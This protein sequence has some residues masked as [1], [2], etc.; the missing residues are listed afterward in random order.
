MGADLGVAQFE[1]AAAVRVVGPI[2]GIVPAL[3]RFVFAAAVDAEEV[4]EHRQADE[5]P[6]GERRRLAIDLR[7]RPREQPPE[8][9]VRTP[10]GTAN[11]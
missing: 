1:Q 6:R 11:R 3:P 8:N 4:D 9:P 10:R 5:Q 2:R 7:V